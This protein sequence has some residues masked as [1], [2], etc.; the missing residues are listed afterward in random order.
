MTEQVVVDKKAQSK[1]Y[2]K[3]YREK[4]IT[5]IAEYKDKTIDEIKLLL[6]DTIEKSRVLNLLLDEKYKQ[7]HKNYLNEQ[8][9]CDS[10]DLTIKRSAMSSHKL[11]KTHKN[12]LNNKAKPTV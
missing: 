7:N 12:L 2:Q 10:C 3:L 9:R 5:M 6:K 4:R 1:I 11:T 8:I